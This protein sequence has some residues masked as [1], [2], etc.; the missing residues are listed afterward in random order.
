MILDLKPDV[1]RYLILRKME[2][3]L[4][5]F[6]AEQRQSIIPVYYNSGLIFG[7]SIIIEETRKQDQ[8]SGM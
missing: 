1:L 6:R 4:L 2:T 7:S 8:Q 3:A 5:Y